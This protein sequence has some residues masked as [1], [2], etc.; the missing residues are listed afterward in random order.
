MA[1]TIPWLVFRTIISRN[2]SSSSRVRSSHSGLSNF[3]SCELSDALVKLG[4]PHGGHIPDIH[5]L[6]P[7]DPST[8]ICGPAYTVKMVLASDDTAPKLDKHFVDEATPN[9]VIVIDAPPRTS[10]YPHAHG[11]GMLSYNSIV[12]KSAVWGGRMVALRLPSCSC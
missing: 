5:M 4:L 10:G 12:A 1:S 11:L 6:S 2:M 7:S 8:R 3:S 9:S